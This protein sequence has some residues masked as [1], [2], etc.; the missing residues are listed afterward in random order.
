MSMT[1]RQFLLTTAGAGIGFILPSFYEKAFD[2][3]ENHREPLILP[4]SNADE[5]LYVSSDGLELYLGDPRQPMPTMTWREF[6][7][8]YQF[9]DY[10]DYL[11]PDDESGE[12]LWIDLE[13]EADPASVLEYWGDEMPSARA[14]D[15]MT[16]LDI[17]PDLTGPNAVGEIRFLHGFPGSDYRGVAAADFISLSLLQERLNQLNTGIRVEM[18]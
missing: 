17:G 6:I 7:D 16:E 14:H 12:A 8:T 18:M 9:G 11:D 15:L 2:F 13:G 4:S 1:R 5:T 10:S 3:W